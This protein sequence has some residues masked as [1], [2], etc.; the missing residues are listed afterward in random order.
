MITLGDGESA[1][2]V[3]VG[4]GDDDAIDAVEGDLL[5]AWQGVGSFLLGM[6]SGIEKEGFS[7]EIENVGIPADFGAEVERLKLEVR[8]CR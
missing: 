8:H 7:V 4:V 2:V 1:N 3:E 5:I 6:H